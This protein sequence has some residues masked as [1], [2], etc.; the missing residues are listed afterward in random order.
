MMPL[1][2]I[3]QIKDPAVAFCLAYVVFQLRQITKDNRVVVERLNSHGDSLAALQQIVAVL[4]ARDES[5]TRRD[6][7][8]AETEKGPAT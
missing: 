1:E 6:M 2:L 7:R 5:R 4:S 3:A 8:L